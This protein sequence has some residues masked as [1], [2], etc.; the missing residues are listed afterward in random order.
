MPKKTEWGT[1]WGFS[2][3]IC[4]KTFKKLKREPLVKKKLSQKS[5]CRKNWNED[6]LTSPSIACYAEKKEQIFWFISFG[7]MVQFDTLK[8]RRTFKNYFDHFVWIGKSV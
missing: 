1:F 7:Q 5:Q 6:P 8:Y 2:T 4:R 3:S